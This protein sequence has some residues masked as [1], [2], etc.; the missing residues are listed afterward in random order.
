M[1]TSGQVDRHRYYTWFCAQA[2]LVVTVTDHVYQSKYEAFILLLTVVLH[3]EQ[4]WIQLLKEEGMHLH[5][6]FK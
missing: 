4:W 2:L 1:T 6:I 5:E 3:I